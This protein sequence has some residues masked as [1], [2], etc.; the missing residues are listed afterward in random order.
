[1]K[2]VDRLSGMYPDARFIMGHAGGDVKAMGHAG[3]GK[4]P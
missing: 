3:C 4:S 2:A 1:M